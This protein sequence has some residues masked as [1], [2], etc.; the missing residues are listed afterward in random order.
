[1]STEKWA[2]TADYLETCNCVHGC[3]C[4]FTGIPT[5]G[6][7]EAIIAYHIRSGHYGNIPLDGLD[8]VAAWAWPNAIHDGNGTAA[9]FVSERAT[10]EQ[11]QAMT[12][13][14]TGRASGQGPFE[15]FAST[16]TT[17]HEPVYTP[18]DFV[19]DGNKS[20]F[21]VPDV[22]EVKLQGFTQPWNNDAPATKIVKL[23]FDK[24]G[25]IFDWAY[26]AMTKVMR[27][28]GGGLNFDHSGRNAFYTFVEYHEQ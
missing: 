11:R 21:M 8:F 6:F 26:A 15:V 2:F 5:D 1:M 24:P 10:V 18:I 14:V 19:F 22:L 12:E 27:I 17:T 13:I 28:F 9:F 3:P 7:C 16:C 20:W 23:S 25:M 4:N